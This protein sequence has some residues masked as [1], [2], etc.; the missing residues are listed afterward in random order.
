MADWAATPEVQ[1]LFERKRRRH[2]RSPAHLPHAHR[3]VHAGLVTAVPLG[4][5]VLPGLGRVD[6]CL[7]EMEFLY[8]IPERNHPLL[9]EGRGRGWNK[10]TRR[11]SASSGG[12]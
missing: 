3:L 6:R 8:P 11:A 2:D 10:R 12:W 7:R 9:G 1:D 5:V 4:E